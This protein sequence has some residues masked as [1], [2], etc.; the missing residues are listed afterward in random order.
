LKKRIFF[1]KNGI[2]I[3]YFMY[4]FFHLLTGIVL[5]YLISDFLNDRRWLIPCAAGAVLPD[6]I[7][8]PIGQFLVPITNGYGRIYTHTLLAA[9]LVLAIGL[10]IWKFKKDPGV[11]GVGVGILSHQILDLM[12]REPANW[13][14]PVLGHFTGAMT[15]G[16]FFLML[17]Q[18]LNN[19]F[20]QI[21]AFLFSAGFLAWVF[22]YRISSLIARNRPGFSRA[23]AAC[24]LLLCILSGI[25]V[26]QGIAKHTI[27]GIG[28]GMPDELVIGGIVIAL[29]AGMVWQWR[30]LI[31]RE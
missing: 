31:A 4:F 24:A 7:D 1:A 15:G 20:E 26:G 12:W 8:K 10:A 28:W 5:G 6:L 17:M 25:I 11:A 13:Y 19:P 29:S 9:I 23:A 22:R 14:Y 30:N 21:L 3:R 16:D 18:E 2:Q 27:P